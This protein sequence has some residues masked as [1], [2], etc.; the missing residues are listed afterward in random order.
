VN[1]I[2]NVLPKLDVG[3]EIIW[4]EREEI[5]GLDGDFTRFQLSAKYAF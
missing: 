3:G 2:K 5:G 4:G 1:V